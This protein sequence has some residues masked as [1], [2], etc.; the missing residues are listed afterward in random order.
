[1]TKYVSVN[2]FSIDFGDNTQKLSSTIEDYNL[3]ELK[4]R[5]RGEIRLDKIKPKTL[6][7]GKMLYF[8]RLF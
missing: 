8:F 2:L 5:W 1:M 3:I 6:E 4:N 7:D